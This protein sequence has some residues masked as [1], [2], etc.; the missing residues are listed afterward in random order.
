MPAVSLC[1]VVAA[2]AAY[3]HSTYC[4]SLVSLSL[5]HH[6]SVHPRMLVALT[7]SQMRLPGA[8]CWGKIFLAHDS[9]LLKQQHSVLEQA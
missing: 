6:L 8:V 4:L 7:G 3:C 9:M 1:R 2:A 5:I